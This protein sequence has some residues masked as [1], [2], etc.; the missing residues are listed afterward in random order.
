MR[1]SRDK[2][3]EICH[4]GHPCMYAERI[5]ALWGLAHTT[6]L[7]LL[8]SLLPLLEACKKNEGKC[9]LKGKLSSSDGYNVGDLKAAQTSELPLSVPYL[10]EPPPV[11]LVPAMGAKWMCRSNGILH[12]FEDRP[13]V[14]KPSTNRCCDFY[15]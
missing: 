12:F 4:V 14:S 15:F 7:F 10:P 3:K 6:G 5:A 8:C 1:T 9:N 2:N 13:S 11:S